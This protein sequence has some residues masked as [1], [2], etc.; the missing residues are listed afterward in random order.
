MQ[1]RPGAPDAGFALV[2]PLKHLS[3]P[4]LH[5]RPFCCCWLLPVCISGVVGAIL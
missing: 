4:R 5:R 3:W 1:A 2:V